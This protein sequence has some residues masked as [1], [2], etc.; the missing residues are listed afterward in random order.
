MSSAIPSRYYRLLEQAIVPLMTRMT[1]LYK[2]DLTHD[3]FLALFAPEEDHRILREAA[4]VI[5]TDGGWHYTDFEGALS[6]SVELAFKVTKVNDYVPLMPRG[7]VIR[8][9]APKQLV[10]RIDERLY[11]Q[12]EVRLEFSRCERLLYWLNANCASTRQIRFLWP[13]ILTLCS[14]DPELEEFGN[15]LRELKRPSSLPVLT[16]PHVKAA[17]KLTAGTLT[18]ASL[19]PPAEPQVSYGCTLH[20]TRPISIKA[21]RCAGALGYLGV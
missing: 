5:A 19:L 15:R 1:N 17:F 3:E 9:D 20:I 14:I 2:I 6:G 13:S 12:I 7:T 16:C 18:A 8:E 10:Q 4:R 21:E 11:K